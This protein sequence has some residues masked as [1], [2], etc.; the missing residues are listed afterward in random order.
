MLLYGAPAMVEHDPGFGHPEQPDRLRAIH[1]RL[2]T[3]RRGSVWHTPPLADADVLRRVH[4]A[5]YVD[6]I[7]ALAGRSATLD[8]D[9]ALS[10]G[11][12]EAARRAA[13]AAVSA[14][15]ALYSG[16]AERT[17]AMVR[18]PG[19]HALADRAMGFCVFNNVAVAAAHARAVHGVQRILVVDWDVHHGN[20]TEAMFADDPGVLFFST[21]QAPF[22]P[23][24]GAVRQQGRGAGL[25]RTVNVPLPAGSTDADLRLAFTEVLRPIAEQF[26]PELV[27]VS[28]G[29]DAHADDPL[30]QMEL[31]EEGFAD[32]CAEVVAIAE[33]DAGGRLALFLEGGYDLDALARS[34]AAC[35]EV[36]EG[37]AAPEQ[38]DVATTAG[39][40]AVR[41]AQDVQRTHWRL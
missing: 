26:A 41:A 38:R 27:L 1:D 2:G 25:G 22:Y 17:F 20:G 28:A 16:E 19:H 13:G 14:V 32:L 36:L 8:P 39:V 21:H 34:V 3:T 6:R 37:R 7:F 40:A 30:G 15:D 10:D 12:V 5:S 4:A 9:T 18:P 33:R 29:F 31:S 35:V 11:S 23:G 24:T